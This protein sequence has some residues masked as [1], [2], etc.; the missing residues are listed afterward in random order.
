MMLYLSS[1]NIF[2]CPKAQDSIDFY[3]L[4][5]FHPESDVSLISSLS[6]SWKFPINPLNCFRPPGYMEI[7]WWIPIGQF[8]DKGDRDFTR[9]Q[10]I[11]RKARAD[12]GKAGI[13]E[14]ML[15]VAKRLEKS[16]VWWGLNQSKL[17]SSCIY[18]P[19]ILQSCLPA[20][21]PSFSNIMLYFA[22]LLPYFC[23]KTTLNASN[24][25]LRGGGGGAGGRGQEGLP[26]QALVFSTACPQFGLGL[27]FLT[28]WD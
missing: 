15:A 14:N 1:R 2:F 10:H 16:S 23:F 22:I 4:T 5:Y 24:L 13:K 21:W 17:R 19:L 7:K 28:S 8:P 26:S 18:Q 25:K 27:S 20:T 6:L 3:W 11:L 12:G 9:E